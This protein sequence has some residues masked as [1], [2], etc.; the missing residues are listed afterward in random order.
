MSGVCVP[1]LLGCTTCWAMF[2]SGVQIGMARIRARHRLILKVQTRAKAGSTGAVL[3]MS[4]FGVVGRLVAIT[5]HL[6]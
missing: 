5:T 4:T 6:M 1:I 3:G 2:G